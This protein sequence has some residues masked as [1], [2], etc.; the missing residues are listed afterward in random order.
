MFLNV[1]MS[2]KGH[3]QPQH[4]H[5]ALHTLLGL[6]RQ[7]KNFTLQLQLF[8]IQVCPGGLPAVSEHHLHFLH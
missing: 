1:S 8:E 2:K 7:Q 6:V 4:C 5:F 3:F